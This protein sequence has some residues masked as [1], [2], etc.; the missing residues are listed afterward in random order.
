VTVTLWHSI[1]A[2][3][4]FRDLPYKVETTRAGAILTV[5]GVK[6]ADVAWTSGDFMNTHGYSAPY[7]IAPEICVK[8]VSP[9]NASH[10]IETKVNLYLAKGATEA[11]VVDQEGAVT[12]FDHGGERS[13]SSLVDDVK[14]K[15]RPT[16]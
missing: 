9:G 2:N 7:S 12:F 5:E 3:P 13:A 14:V 8:I 6:V 4:F 16:S 10:E 15:K 1:I 11:W